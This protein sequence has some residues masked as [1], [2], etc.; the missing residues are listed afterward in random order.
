MA[1]LPLGYFPVA[2]NFHLFEILADTDKVVTGEEVLTAWKQKATTLDDNATQAVPGLVLIQDTLLAMGGLGVVDIPCDDLYSANGATRHLATIS[3][4][5]HGGLHFTTEVILAAAFLMPMLK[6][7]NFAYPFRACETPLQYAYKK[8]GN[9]EYAKQHTYA[10]MAAEGRMDNF[11]T[12]MTGKFGKVAKIPDR[13]QSLGYDLGALLETRPPTIKMVDIGGGRGELLLEIKEAFSELK[14]EDLIVQEFNEDLGDM[15]G[16]I[17]TNWDYR[18]KNTHP[19]TGAFIYHLSHILRNLPDLDA[20][21]L[22][23][24]VAEAMAPYSRILVHESTKSVNYAFLHSTMMELF[25]GRERNESD[26]REIAAVS[27]LRVT[28]LACPALGE[29]VI[30]LQKP[31]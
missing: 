9:E 4:A 19:V 22:L 7:T 27:G 15:D 30:Q 1:T 23:Q 29:G 25:G 10:I 28:F 6:A 13:L 31:W 14:A 12:F 16:F 3:S 8:M 20:V 26:W 18:G 17:V 11:N 21:R 2:A 24:K 5:L